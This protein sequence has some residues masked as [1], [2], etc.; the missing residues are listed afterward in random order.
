MILGSGLACE[1]GC[2]TFSRPE[3]EARTGCHPTLADKQLDSEEVAISMDV[4]VL[5]HH[6]PFVPLILI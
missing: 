5:I 3:I 2:W 4:Q 6:L 1:Y